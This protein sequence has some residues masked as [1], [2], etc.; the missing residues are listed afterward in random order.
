MKIYT[1]TG[2]DGKTSTFSGSRISKN[3]L[4]MNAQGSVDELNATIGMVIA[5]SENREINDILTDIQS[6]LFIVG[7]EI[8]LSEKGDSNK[9]R[10]SNVKVKNIENIIDQVENK[11]PKLKNFILP[12][13]TVLAAHLHRARTICRRAERDLVAFIEDS[14][15]QT[16]AVKYLNRLADLLFILARHA[17]IIEKREE[18]IWKI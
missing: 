7:S 13:G 11:L 14:N 4:I 15:Y 9:I 8:T 1:R 3:S 18:E 10:I 5:M 17:N 6:E 2:D 16:L 12:G